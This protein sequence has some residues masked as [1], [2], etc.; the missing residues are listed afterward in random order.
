MCRFFIQR[1]SPSNPE[2]FGQGVAF[3]KEPSIIEQKAYRDTWGRGLE[4]YLSWFYETVVL[5]NELLAETGTLYVHL[6]Y[7]V[8]HYAKVVLDE[9]FGRDR[10]SSSIVWKRTSAHSGADRYGPVHD[11]ILVYT[12][13]DSSIWN[14]V[15]QAYDEEYVATFFEQSDPDG[16]KWKR[17]DLT[18]PGIRA[19]DS[20]KPWRGVDVTAKGRHW[21]PASYV[22]DK[23]RQIAGEELS[24][25]PLIERLDKLDKVGLIHWPEKASG[26]P[27]Y[28]CYLEDMPGT[29]LQDVW[30]DI[31]PIHNLAEERVGYGTSFTSST[32]SFHI[33]AICFRSVLLVS[34]SSS[35]AS[36]HHFSILKLVKESVS[37]ASVGI[38]GSVVSLR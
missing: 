24:K 35:L 16:K 33:G 4:S 7:H 20:G 21:Q 3:T 36:V 15:Y 12:K 11:I 9:I 19:G 1:N 5:L 18:G 10:F 25:Y 26:M 28:K 13:S 22:Y 27:R 8:A 23:Y 38:L 32:P 14:E 29:P 6:D 31:R 37:N 34:D 2:R 17:G 30:T